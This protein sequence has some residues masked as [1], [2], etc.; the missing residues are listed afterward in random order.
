[1]PVEINNFRSI[2]EARLNPRVISAIGLL[3]ISLIAAIAISASANRSVYVWAAKSQLAA[4][5]EI[6]AIDIKKVKVFLPENSKLYFSNKAKIIGSITMRTIGIDELIPATAISSD[7]GA[8]NRKSVPIKVAR[9]DYPSDLT[10]GSTID[11]YALP[12]RETSTKS[13]AIQIAHNVI[14][15]SIDLRGKDIGGEIGVVV[16]LNVDEIDSFLTSTIGSKLVVVR[17]AI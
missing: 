13:D 16:R 10:K 5:N 1:M 14:I 15:E 12:A 3:A 7:K 9:N 6:T 2:R 11:I 8:K 17:S 4:G